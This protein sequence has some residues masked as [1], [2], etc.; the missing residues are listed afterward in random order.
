MFSSSLEPAAHG[1]RPEA[2]FAGVQSLRWLLAMRWLLILGQLALLAATSR[3]LA[4]EI[5]LAAIGALVAAEVAWNLFSLWR[6]RRG[7]SVRDVELFAQLCVDAVA[8]S[9]IVALA[10]GA[11]NPLISLYLPLIAIGAAILPRRLAAALTALSVAAYSGIAALQGDAHIHD[12]ERAFRHH[13]A[14]MWVIFVLSAATI[15]WF[16]ARTT[17]AIRTRDAELATAREAALRNERVVALGNLAAGAAHEL[18]T[19]LATIAVLA[20]ELERR[21]DLPDAAREDLTLMSAQVR[22]CK[23]LITQLAERAGVDRAEAARSLDL[24]AWLEGLIARWRAQ[25]PLVDPQ[26]RLLGPRPAPTVAP[27]DTLAQALLNLFNNAADASPTA[28]EIEARWDGVALCLDVLDRG[29]GIAP[30]LAPRLGRA[31]VPPPQASGLGLGLVLS[32]SAVER[33]GGRLALRSRDDGGT[34][35][36]VELPLAAL[37]TA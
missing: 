25:R 6:L 30:E 36:S 8:L 2:A 11:T 14:G 5:P 1:V 17:A 34:C 27:D 12:A 23:R 7:P 13:L 18:G 9:A 33:I 22:E 37:A 4:G 28:I 35:A 31:P 29:R 3:L 19:P 16:V 26:V 15:A 32:F 10:G 24:E 21:P 20:G